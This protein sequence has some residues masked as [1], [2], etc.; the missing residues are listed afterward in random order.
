MSATSSHSAAIWPGAA[1]RCELTDEP[2]TSVVICVSAQTA[3]TDG[4][5]EK[6]PTIVSSNSSKTPISINSV[7]FALANSAREE[8]CQ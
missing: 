4:T 8:E 1:L 3:V 5:T 6:M 2:P 7:W